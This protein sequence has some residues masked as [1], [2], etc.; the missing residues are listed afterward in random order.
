[1]KRSRKDSRFS[2]TIEKD[3]D[4]KDV[5]VY[6]EGE[7]VGFLRVEYGSTWAAYRPAAYNA[8]KGDRSEWQT[9]LGQGQSATSPDHYL[10]AAAVGM[11]LEH[12]DFSS[13]PEGVRWTQRQATTA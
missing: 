13:T 10:G 6:F 2:Y 7:W 1:M 11:A 12:C 4:G 3:G 5:K 9:R 8:D